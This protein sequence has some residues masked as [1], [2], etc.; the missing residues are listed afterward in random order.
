MCRN[1]ILCYLVK[2]KGVLF[3]YYQICKEKKST[4]VLRLFLYSRLKP[5][6]R[7]L[8]GGGQYIS[9]PD[10]L[11]FQKTENECS[12]KWN[13]IASRVERKKVKRGLRESRAE[14]FGWR[15]CG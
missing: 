11:I 5:T 12:V 6:A 7:A 2:G 10:T 4:I 14:V 8:V 13:S 1:K 3:P 15:R 9:R